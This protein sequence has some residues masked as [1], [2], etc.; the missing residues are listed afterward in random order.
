[1]VKKTTVLCILDGFGLGEDTEYNAI[2]KA[3]TPIW[4]NLINS[5]PMSRLDASGDS[6]GLPDGQMGNSEVGHLNIGSGRIVEQLLP[7][8]NAEIKSGKIKDKPIFKEFV[9]QTKLGNN[10]C[11]LVGIISDGGVHG[12][13]EHVLVLAEILAGQNIQV[14]L[15]AI[16]DGRDTAPKSALG[17]MAEVQNRIAG[18]SNIKIASVVGRYYAMDRDNNWDRVSV[19]HNMLKGDGKQVDDA[20][21]YINDSYANDITDEFILPAI[22]SGAPAMEDHDSIIFTNF[23]IYS[24]FI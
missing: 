1:M 12:Y 9:K 20:L 8:I 3:N 24:N 5:Y 7:T 22:I 10:T 11:H 18:Y 4:D 14:Y 13:M 15:H 21:S 23:I 6:V 16:L 19:A 2:Y 17:F